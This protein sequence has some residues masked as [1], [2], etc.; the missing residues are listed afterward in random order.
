M[1]ECRPL[2]GL[3]SCGLRSEQEAEPGVWGGGVPLLK[4]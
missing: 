2:N 4:S 1:R 3:K